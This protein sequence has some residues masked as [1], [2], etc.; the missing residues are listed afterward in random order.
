MAA[1]VSQLANFHTVL[2]QWR[3]HR[4]PLRNHDP[5]QAWDSADVLL[6]Q[7]MADLNCRLPVLVNDQFGALAVACQQTQIAAM[8]DSYISVCSWQHNLQINQ[9]ATQII[10][11]T[12]LTAVPAGIDQ[13]LMKLPKSSSL[14]SYQ[15]QR[16]AASIQQPIALLAA[17]KS[18][19]FSPAIRALFEQYCDQV[20]VSL[21]EKKAR[22]LSAQLRP[23]AVV[24]PAILNY[25]QDPDYP[26]QLGHYPGVFSRNQLDLGARLFLRHLPAAGADQV[27]DLGCGNGVLG[28]RYAQL[29]PASKILWVDESYLAIASCQHN[30]EL[31]LGS[32]D[33]RYQ[34]AV[35]DC[36]S[37][38]AAA[39]ADLILCNP[40]FHQEHAITT[41]IA[42]QMF[43]DSKR[44]LR[45][46]GELRVVA[47]RH[48]AYHQ[49]LERLFGAVTVV[50][51]N[52][53]FVLLSVRR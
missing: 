41:H 1:D 24:E 22:V 28:L 29:S 40:P 52:P 46:G 49:P 25:W 14:L 16:L 12:G 11:L 19:L 44:V 17:A 6:H 27:I 37:Q 45:H 39:S 36:L 31:N 26:L 34:T 13:V 51:S 47:N 10:P 42:Q 43:R 32:T 5:L 50:A 35:D 3:L 30:I 53:K 21:I 18:K 15:L 4:Y 7:H 8:S 9:L 48:L 20:E 23:L 33:T 2:G 38:Q